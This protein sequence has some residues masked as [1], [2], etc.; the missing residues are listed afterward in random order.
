VLGSFIEYQ[1]KYPTQTVG[2]AMNEKEKRELKVST[3]PA[4]S[5]HKY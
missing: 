5:N 4:K 2:I 3:T 1:E